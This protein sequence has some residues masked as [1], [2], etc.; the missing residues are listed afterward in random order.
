MPNSAST[1]AVSLNNAE[2]RMMML[3]VAESY[4]KLARRAEQRGVDQAT[5]P[6]RNGTG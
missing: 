3:G 2:G 1:R 6:V 5:V 4:E